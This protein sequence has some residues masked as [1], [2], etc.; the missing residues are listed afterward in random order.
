[1]FPGILHARRRCIMEPMPRVQRRCVPSP[2]PRLNWNLGHSGPERKG[3]G[4]MPFPE[5]TVSPWHD[6]RMG[7]ALMFLAGRLAMRAP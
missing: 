3:D 6:S 7:L 1:M 5:L 2:S 4:W